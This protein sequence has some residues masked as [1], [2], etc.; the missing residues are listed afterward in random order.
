MSNPNSLSGQAD[1]NV[2]T[3][4]LL[5]EAIAAARG[6]LDSG[7]ACAIVGISKIIRGL[8]AG[9]EMAMPPVVNELH[10]Q[11]RQAVQAHLPRVIEL[12]QS[13][14]IGQNL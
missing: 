3:A 7:D 9:V 14:G 13:I 5:G 2:D 4:Y 12:G 8:T 10:L 11:A 1:N 6:I